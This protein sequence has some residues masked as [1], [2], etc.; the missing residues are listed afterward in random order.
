MHIASVMG[1]IKMFYSY[2]VVISAL[3]N[4]AL[5]LKPLKCFDG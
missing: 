4:G 1:V 2:L 3:F 5:V